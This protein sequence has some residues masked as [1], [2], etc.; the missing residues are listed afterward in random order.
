MV[1]LDNQSGLLLWYVQISLEW[2]STTWPANDHNHCDSSNGCRTA[3]CRRTS[4]GYLPAVRMQMLVYD[5][6]CM[7]RV[8]STKDDRLH[9]SDSSASS[10][11]WPLHCIQHHIYSHAPID[12]KC[13][14]AFRQTN[15]WRDRRRR[16]GNDSQKKACA[17][18]SLN[19][20]VCEL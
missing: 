18:R 1:H 9:T 8:H 4:R 3:S 5:Q 15:S 13:L 14:C 11:Q 12:I 19:I 2:A 10:G 17:S 6:S 7:H 16:T 20:L